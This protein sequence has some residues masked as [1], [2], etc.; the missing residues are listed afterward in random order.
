MDNSIIIA[1]LVASVSI[2][3]GIAAI[4]NQYKMDK[5]EER[6]MMRFYDMAHSFGRDTNYIAPTFDR[7]TTYIVPKKSKCEYCKSAII[8]E[9]E[10]CKQCG[11]P[12]TNL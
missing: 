12:L 10:Y 2:I 8:G 4:I 9:S 11:A 3:P 1:I 5:D 7:D 6:M